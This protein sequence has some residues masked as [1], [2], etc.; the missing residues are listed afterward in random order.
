MTELNTFELEIAELTSLEEL[1]TIEETELDDSIIEELDDENTLE[2]DGDS[3]LELLEV[4]E[5]SSTIDDAMDF[6][7]LDSIGDAEVETLAQCE[8]WEDGIC[9]GCTELGTC[10]EWT[11]L[12]AGDS[13]EYTPE[14]ACAVL[15]LR[16]A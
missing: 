10:S 2:L 8:K 4:T 6:E 13:C 11:K 3:T 7:E 15:D 9:S 1:D 14:Y 16:G 12:G 5:D